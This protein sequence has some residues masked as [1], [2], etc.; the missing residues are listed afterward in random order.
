MERQP[1]MAEAVGFDRYPGRDLLEI[2][3]GLGTDLLQFARGGARV[4]GLDLTVR[5]VA[6]ARNRLDL[7]DVPGTFLTGDAENLPFPDA[8]FDVVYSFGVLHHT[9][10]TARAVREIR[11]VLRPGGEAGTMLYHSNSSHYYLGY[12]LTMLSRLRG[13]EK[14]MGRSEYFRIYDGEENPLGKA[15]TRRQVREL[16]EEFEIIDQKSYETWR[17]HLGAMTNR[18]LIGLGK[19]FGFYLV[20]RVRTPRT[21]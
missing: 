12:P 4:T 2:G 3:C 17:P 15:Y 14:L 8:S 19:R 5:S 9:P 11:R 7:E 20:T 1:F 13:G 18:V 16:F 10:D 6:L 21:P